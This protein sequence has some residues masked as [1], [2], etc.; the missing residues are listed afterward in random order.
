[1]QISMQ[2]TMRRSMKSNHLGGGWLRGLLIGALAAIPMLGAPWGALAAAAGETPP[3]REQA[4]ARH[5]IQ[6]VGGRVRGEL[7]GIRTD[8]AVARLA[9]L[10]GAR[11]FWSPPAGNAVVHGRLTGLSTEQALA[12]LLGDRSYL[13][14]LGE[15]PEIHVLSGEEDDAALG[16]SSARAS[17]G[18]QPTDQERELAQLRRMAEVDQ[19]AHADGESMDVGAELD[20]IV[21]SR[22]EPVVRLAAAERL[23][24]ID[25]DHAASALAWLTSD[26]DPMVR[27]RAEALLAAED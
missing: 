14:V 11:L 23:L 27:R 13:L 20:A 26:A 3:P 21:R 22:D 6:L 5:T 1:M 16:G 19:I 10:I 7:H 4:P 8:Q 2:S 12:R 17:A 9:S 24:A 18:A 25:P 15:R